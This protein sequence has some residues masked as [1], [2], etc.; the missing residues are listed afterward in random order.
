MN[1]L[2]LFSFPLEIKREQNKFATMINQ[3]TKAGIKNANAISSHCY[4]KLEREEVFGK[5]SAFGNGF[6]IC[7]KKNE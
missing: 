3:G 1:G 2:I 7:L 4:F 5:I 6:G